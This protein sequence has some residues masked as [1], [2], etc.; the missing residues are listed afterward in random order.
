MSRRFAVAIG[1]GLVIEG[2]IAWAVLDA[3]YPVRPQLLCVTNAT[4]GTT[5]AFFGYANE[6]DE[7]RV[8]PVGGDNAFSPG[9]ADRGQPTTFAPGSSGRYPKA[10]FSVAFS[11]PSLTWKLGPREVEATPE[12]P[13]C[14]VP[15]RLRDLPDVAMV[16]P[17]K[18]PEPPP[19]PPKPP[20]PEPEPEPPKPEEPPPEPPKS[21]E[22]PPKA[23]PPRGQPKPT[24]P[25][26]K[27]AP[28]PTE[29]PPLVLEGLT[30]L[31]RGVGIQTGDTTIL[32]DAGIAA[33]RENTVP[34]RPA[35]GDGVEGGVP[36]GV[37]GGTVGAVV[38]K[39]PKVKRRVQ[40]VYPDDAP[41][42]G[43]AVV[44]GLSL[45]IGADGK[46]KQ[47][48]VVRGAGAAFDREA[49]VV[50]RKLEFYPATENGEPVE[51]WIPW[52]VEFTPDDW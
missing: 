51:Q 8:E 31:E 29:P 15:E 5:I 3:Y 47:V 9:E 16:L 2:G 19:E 10:A 38:R 28:E 30:G 25:V 35:T 1:L 21:A 45:L 18:P 33:T 36:G 48:K 26:P 24:K 37:P 20:E 34:P 17:E 32:G 23:T 11:G 14:P 12:S 52:T 40:G 7:A 43:R 44:V 42:L 39:P 4:P 41:R 27:D 46:V 49:K 13:P 22:P 50:G 6:A